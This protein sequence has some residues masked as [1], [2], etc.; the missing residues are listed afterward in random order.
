M[1]WPAATWR[2]V[3]N[4]VR[5]ILYDKAE[6][7]RILCKGID[8]CTACLQFD[9]IQPNQSPNWRLCHT[10]I[11]DPCS[12]CSLD[13]VSRTLWRWIF[14]K[15]CLSRMMNHRPCELATILRFSFVQNVEI[16][17][18]HWTNFAYLTA[19]VHFTVEKVSQADLL[20]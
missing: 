7:T 9:W 4:C 10:L 6:N 8:H 2:S 15:N 11:L 17:Y 14:E 5:I 12:E 3:F 19:R 13:K 20:Y 1:K 16:F 18:F